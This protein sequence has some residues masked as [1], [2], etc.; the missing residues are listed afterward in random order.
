MVKAVV[1]VDPHIARRPYDLPIETGPPVAA[2]WT[3]ALEKAPINRV[4]AVLGPLFFLVVS[5]LAR[6]VK[7]LGASPLDVQPQL[8][9]KIV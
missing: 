8:T 2:V 6:F 9:Q 1:F 7:S 4:L 3:L 5:G